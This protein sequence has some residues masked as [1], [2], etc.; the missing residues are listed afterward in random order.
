M[1]KVRLH[2][3]AEIE[4]TEAAAYYETQ[5]VDLGKRF[6]ASV[7]MPSAAS[8]STRVFILWWTSM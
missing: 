2:P 5:Q 4:M 6:L 8:E 3:E 7:Q 1:M